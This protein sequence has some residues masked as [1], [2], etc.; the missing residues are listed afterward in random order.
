MKK[1][2]TLVST[3]SVLSA[4]LISSGAVFAASNGS[5]TE[6]KQTPITTNLQAPS[7]PGNP[8][9]PQPDGPNQ[10]NNSNNTNNNVNGTFGIA[11]QPSG[12][13]FTTDNLSSTGEQLIPIT[14]NHQNATYNVGVKDMTHDTKGW[15]LTA[16][17]SWTTNSIQGAT[18][19]TTNN[20]E[21]KKNIN[22]GGDFN[23]SKDLIPVTSGVTGT[24]NLSINSSP[25]N[26]MVGQEGTIHNAVY[27]YDLGSV[28]LKI[29]DTST[30]S[31][32]S[33]SGNV[34]WN[35]QVTP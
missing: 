13:T 20:G 15:T 3:V 17:L 11:Y 25:Q 14:N 12:F 2:K 7:N 5:A 6:Q 10:D 18:I 30:V 33:Y 1:F 24:N 9:P 8:T 31:A 4:T 28:S 29:P 21:V 27:D 35:L 32:G 23:N 26:V 16:Q 22:T 19:E 34:N